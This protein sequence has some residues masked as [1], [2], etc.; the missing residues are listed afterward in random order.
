MAIIDTTSD[1]VTVS[2][3]L[4][5]I[6]R[7]TGKLADAELHFVGGPLA[8][9]KLLGFAIWERRDGG[10]HVTFPARQYSAG[11]QRRSFTLLRDVSGQSGSQVLRDLILAAYAAVAPPP[12]E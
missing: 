10:R 4:S 5:N 3:S 7:P 9:L 12:S 2:I 1:T 8:G 6:D 11:G